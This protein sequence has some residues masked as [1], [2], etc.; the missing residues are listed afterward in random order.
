MLLSIY[1]LPFN[2][3]NLPFQELDKFE[4]A[5]KDEEF[6]KLLVDYAK[7]ISDPE[8]KKVS[9]FSLLSHHGNIAIGLDLDL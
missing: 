7:E 1:L 2:W 5:M 9:W 8:N 4:Q 3:F 6:R